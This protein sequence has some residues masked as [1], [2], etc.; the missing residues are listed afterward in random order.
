MDR[1]QEKPIATERLVGVGTDDLIKRLFVPDVTAAALYQSIF[2]RRVLSA[3]AELMAAVLDNGIADY[4]R[5]IGARDKRSAR[6]FAEAETW[7]AGGDSD[8]AFSFDNCCAALGIDAS[9]LRKGLLSWQ[10]TPR[11]STKASLRPYKRNVCRKA[12]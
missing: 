1:K 7:I 3:E 10:P 8:W 2:R 5:F 12:A 6:R 9:Y 4:E 11:A